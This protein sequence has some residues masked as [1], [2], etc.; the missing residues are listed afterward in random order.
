MFFDRATTPQQKLGTIVCLPNSC[1]ITHAGRPT[2]NNTLKYGLQD[3]GTIITRRLRPL[4]SLHLKATQYFGVPG[5]TIFDA[6][7]TVR[8]VIAHAEHE[9]LPVCVLT[10]D[11][12]RAFDRLSHEYLFTILC[13]YGPSTH[14]ITLLR[15]LYSEATS[16][17]Q[18]N[19]HL[20][21][22]SPIHCGVR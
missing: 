14:F 18:I 16:T 17:V 19:G 15:V 7:A 2:P 1:P 13:K 12:Q 9:K 8:D 6:V 4:L 22:Q 20:H 10:L 5:N 11:F 21:G 3:L